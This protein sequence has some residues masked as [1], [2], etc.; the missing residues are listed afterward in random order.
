ME[1]ED[2]V[3]LPS[4]L[5]FFHFCVRCPRLSMKCVLDRAH[6]ASA[7]SLWESLTTL[8]ANEPEMRPMASW[9]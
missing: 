9:I 3:K 7:Q 2:S 6:S 1:E 8:S 4:A 5:L